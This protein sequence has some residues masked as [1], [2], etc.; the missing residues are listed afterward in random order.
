[1]DPF[2]HRVEFEVAVGVA[3]HQLAVEHPAPRREAQL[4]EVAVEGFAAARLD[5][6]LVA[7]DKDDRPEPIQLRLISPLL[8]LRQ[9]FAGKRKLRLDR[10]REAEASP[11]DASGAAVP[12]PA[13]S[14][15]R[16]RHRREQFLRVVVLRVLADLVGGPLLDDLALVHHRDPVGDVA[17]DADVV[18]DEEVGEAELVLE[19]VEQ[20]DDLRLDRDVE[21]RDRLVADHQLRFQRQRPGDPD[22]LPLAAGELVREAVVVLGGEPDPLQQLLHLRAAG[23]TPEATPCRFS[24][25]PTIWPTRLRGFSEA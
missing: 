10:R 2:L 18:G 23:P 17:D 3:D 11:L 24:G 6:D 12:L 14:R 25:S 15:I 21:R 13:L 19:V 4:G 16:N 7:V 8:A 5:V 9:L 20:V 1:M 22:P